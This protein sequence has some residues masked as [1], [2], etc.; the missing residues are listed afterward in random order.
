MKKEK[1]K[2]TIPVKS[3]IPL[4]LTVRGPNY[5]FSLDAP[6]SRILKDLQSIKGVMDSLNQNIS[7]VQLTTTSAFPTGVTTL[8]AP[9]INAS[10]STMDNIEALFKTPWGQES[11]SVA[12]VVKA[13]EAN[14]VPDTTTYVSVCLSR[15]VKKHI[16]RRIRKAGKWQY[17]K[18]PSG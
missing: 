3:N 8:E 16:L 2:K 13:L 11:R 15:L 10:K 1:S 4:H 14:A 6:A 18:L 9:T 7:G 5:E 17:Y 12:E